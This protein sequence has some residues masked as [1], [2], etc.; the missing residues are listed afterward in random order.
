MVHKNKAHV[1]IIGG[2]MAGLS[3]AATLAEQGIQTTLFESGP[4]FGGRA[5]SVAI[6][7]NSQ[8]FQVDNGQHILLGAYHETL[9]LLE[10]VGVQEKQAFLRLPLALNMISPR[11]KKS[12]KLANLNFLPHP[13]NQLFGFL[14]CQGLSFK[15]RVSVVT[16]IVKLKKNNYRLTSDA[17]LK[18]YLLNNHQSN[19]TIKFL[20]EP[21]CL[22]ALNTPIES[23]SSK[24]FLNVLHDAFNDGKND[25]D[26]LIPKLD[27][28]QILSTPI[29][30]YLQANQSTVLNNKLVRSIKPIEHGF[31]V[32][33]RLEKYTFSHVIIATAARKLKDLTGDLPK[34][35]FVISQTDVY[36]YQPI[37]TVYL[38]Y[39]NHITLPQ[40]MLGLVDLTS[41]WVFDR[42]QLCGQQ[43]LMAVVI[44]AK[45]NHQKLT[46]DMLA[47]K[48][49]QELH[50]AFPYLNKP[51]WHK[52]IAEKRAT[53]SCNV[54]LPRPAN[55]TPYLNL[56]LAGDYTYADYPATIEGA[57]R[58]GIACANLILK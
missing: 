4:H 39:P 27:L 8:T 24:V 25:S 48:V 30:R 40:P 32:A 2:G 19:Q 17:L 10:K 51:L 31:E 55:V 1:A 20:W 12:F 58:S 56:F 14:C 34:L 29:V 53:F 23:A 18:D 37:Y 57:V 54:N 9:K 7:F 26:F 41:Q 15:E 11:H 5:R 44:S 42:G 49:A 28:S 43:G 13:L 33:T 35:D 47:L 6:E 36:D 22:A 38:Q 3:A 50:Q 16:L 52:V 21:L 46:Q 45:G